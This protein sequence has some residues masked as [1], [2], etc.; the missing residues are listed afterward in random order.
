M[1]LK[2]SFFLSFVFL[3]YKNETATK[4]SLLVILPNP[5]AGSC[6][7][8]CLLCYDLSKKWF[9]CYSKYLFDCRNAL[10]AGEYNDGALA[11]PTKIWQEFPNE[12][13]LAIA[14]DKESK[15]SVIFL[16]NISGYK[17]KTDLLYL[18]SLIEN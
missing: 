15:S 2:P 5:R 9:S 12:N 7:H 18:S 4:L 11:A 14:I 8:C 10:Y 1:G 16:L 13:V 17:H 6:A 3:S